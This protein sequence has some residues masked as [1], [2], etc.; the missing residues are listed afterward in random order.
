MNVELET[1][2]PVTRIALQRAAGA[3]RLRVAAVDGRTRLKTLYQQGSAKI[4]F[5]GRSGD[6]ILINTAGGLAEGDRLTWNVELDE[7]AR[8][9][10]TTQACEKVYRATGSDLDAASQVETQLSVGA[11]AR[12]DWLPQET[13]L[14]DHAR[15]ERRLDA[16]LTGDGELLALEAVVLGRRAMGESAA[17]A[18]L[19]DRWRVSRD[20]R[21]VFA[22]DTRLPGAAAPTSEPALLDGAGAYAS[23]LLVA[24]DAAGALDAVRALLPKESGASAWDG[25]LFC[26]IL[27]EDG[28]ALRRALI[29]ILTVLRG[30]APLPRLW[31]I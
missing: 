9:T 2:G 21:A 19:H 4:R 12:L 22:D 5:S 11:G 16:N 31:T 24:H 25:K 27:A 20:G 13:I 18:R 17:R 26:R 14:F 6:A 15:L 8:Q 28:R 23:V 29:P 7:G 1:P 3:A 10:V 30:G